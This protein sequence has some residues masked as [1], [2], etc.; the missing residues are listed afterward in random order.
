VLRGT[1]QRRSGDLGDL[2]RVRLRDGHYRVFSP[3]S[4]IAA[5]PIA[6]R[7]VPRTRRTPEPGNCG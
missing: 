3:D 6:K 5:T 1:V 4:V 2:W 7:T